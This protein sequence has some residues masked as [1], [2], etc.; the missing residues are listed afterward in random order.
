MLDKHS[1]NAPHQL[2]TDWTWYLAEFGE[3]KAR[4]IMREIQYYNAYGRLP[5][6]AWVIER[7][8]WVNDSAI[9]IHRDPDARSD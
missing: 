6:D 3:P 8:E 4:A 1:W 5:E 9:I 2:D 7:V